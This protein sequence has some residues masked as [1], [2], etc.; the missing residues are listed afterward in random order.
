MYLEGRL[1]IRGN[2]GV[3]SMGAELIIGNT[4]VPRLMVECENKYHLIFGIHIPRTVYMN[5]VSHLRIGSRPEYDI[6]IKEP[7]IDLLWIITYVHGCYFFKNERSTF[8]TMYKLQVNRPVLLFQ[9]DEISFGNCSQIFDI[10][11]CENRKDVIR[12]FKVFTDPKCKIL[13]RRLLEQD[14][15][16][17]VEI[18]SLKIT[19]TKGEYNGQNFT[20]DGTQTRITMGRDQTNTFKFNSSFVS[21]QQL[22]IQYLKIYGWVIEVPPDH[23]SKNSTYL[24]LS[25]YCYPYNQ[26]PSCYLGVKTGAES[27]FKSGN[28][29]LTVT[30]FYLYIA[31]TD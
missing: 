17:L 22:I 11:I 14:D 23:G 27:H 1:Q 20:F 15:P 16:Y 3:Q 30:T 18:P 24:S 26:S 6:F 5:E 7:D 9:H 2:S 29:S 4:L 21:T 19:F 25:S 8:Q 31:Q 10:T 12:L 28:T 13:H